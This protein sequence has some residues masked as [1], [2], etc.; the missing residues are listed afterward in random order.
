[1]GNVIWGRFEKLPKITAS[2]YEAA[3]FRLQAEARQQTDV[4]ARQLRTLAGV[5]QERA[6][7]EGHQRAPGKLTQANSPCSR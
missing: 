1:M 3:A 5:F 6:K 7:S 4:T 2:E